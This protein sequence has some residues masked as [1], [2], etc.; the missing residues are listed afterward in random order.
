MIEFSEK[1]YSDEE[2]FNILNPI[3]KKWFK[4]KFPSF[5]TPQKYGV[6]PI[7]SRENILLSAPTG[8]GKTLTSFLSILNE[9][10]DSSEKGILE[11]RVYCVYISPLK[12]LNYDIHHNLLEPLKEME[13]LSKKKINVRADVRTGDTTPYQ[14]QKMLKKPPHILITTPESLAIML[15]SPKFKLLLH[16]VEWCIIDEVHALAENKRGVHLSLSLERLNRISP[17]MTRIGLSATISPLKDIA[18]YLVGNENGKPRPCKI[19]DVQFI[20]NM[21]LKVLSPVPDLVDQDHKQ[22]HNS[23]YKLL[24]KIIVS[25]TDNYPDNN[26]LYYKIR[27]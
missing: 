1:T 13:K 15:T 14:R 2:I 4:S 19:L 24:D 26:K 21:K 5:C 12:A 8:S 27:L 22:M 16:N 25:E 23:L 11:D 3:V 7:H 10:I 18:G 9:L 17:A 6:M 20:K